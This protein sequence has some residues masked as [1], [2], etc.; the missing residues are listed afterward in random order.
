MKHEYIVHADKQTDSQTNTEST[1]SHTQKITQ[2]KSCAQIDRQTDRQ[3]LTDSGVTRG[4]GAQG[5]GQKFT[6][7]TEIFPSSLL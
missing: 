2:P 6:F 5:Q 4:V 3:R 7:S 1:N